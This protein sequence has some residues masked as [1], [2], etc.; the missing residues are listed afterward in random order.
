MDG[1][2]NVVVVQWGPFDWVVPGSTVVVDSVEVVCDNVELVKLKCG[3]SLA[4]HGTPSWISKLDLDVELARP[5]FE[6]AR[7]SESFHICDSDLIDHAYRGSAKST[8][9]SSY[10]LM[11][12][13]A[14]VA[15]SERDGIEVLWMLFRDESES[16]VASL[17]R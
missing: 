15:S 8:F 3:E 17:E 11:R 6:S 7:V 9:P 5:S 2:G 14:G 13:R 4:G 16:G 12:Y 1:G 10:L